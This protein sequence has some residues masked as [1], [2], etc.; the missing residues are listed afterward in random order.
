M[1][2]YLKEVVHNETQMNEAT[3]DKYY[4]DFLVDAKGLKVNISQYCKRP[5]DI[6]NVDKFCKVCVM[7]SKRILATND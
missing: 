6:E 1:N 4:G 7:N 5:P 2:N 3:I